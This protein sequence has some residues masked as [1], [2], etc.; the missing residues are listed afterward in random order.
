MPVL[1]R[2]LRRP[3]S[4]CFC[5]PESPEPPNEKFSW[6]VHMERS[7]EEAHG[8]GSALRLEGKTVR[9][10]HLT[11]QAKP[12]GDASPALSAFNYTEAASN[13]RR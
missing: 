11:I 7:R 9:P 5:S 2:V 10:S 13:T 1:A 4:L 3:G 12:P 6:R 8:A